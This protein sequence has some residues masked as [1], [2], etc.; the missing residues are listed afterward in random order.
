MH[1]PYADGHDFVRSL[2][3]LG[4]SEPAPGHRPLTP[5]AF[6]RLLASLEGGFTVTYHVLFGEVRG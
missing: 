4:A 3:A 1:Q 2:K 5:G 6:R